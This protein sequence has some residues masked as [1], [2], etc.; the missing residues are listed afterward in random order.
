MLTPETIRYLGSDISWLSTHEPFHSWR[1]IAPQ[2]SL[3]V[4]E[5]QLYYDTDSPIFDSVLLDGEV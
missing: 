1:F 5:K 4:M 2:L 3:T